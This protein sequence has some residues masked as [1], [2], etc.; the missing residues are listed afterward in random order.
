MSELTHTATCSHCKQ[1]FAATEEYAKDPQRVC[2]SCSY[3]TT[4]PTDARV[5]AERIA[6]SMFMSG[7]CVRA[8][9][10]RFQNVSGTDL[11]CGWSEPAVAAHIA[12]ILSPV[13]E[14]GAGMNEL[15][16]SLKSRVS[17]RHIAEIDR[18]RAAWGA[19][20]RGEAGK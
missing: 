16:H 17:E 7:D 8:A 10:L 6:A 9:R 15:I 3:A 20:L 2:Q 11:G 13:L 19:A 18:V 4:S 14:A 12:A 5:L 1:D